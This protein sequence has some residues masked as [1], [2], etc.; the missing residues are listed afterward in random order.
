MNV[1]PHT[2]GV[3]NRLRL[4]RNACLAVAVAPLLAVG[5]DYAAVNPAATAAAPQ[6]PAPPANGEMGFVVT[7]FHPAFHNGGDKTDCPD[8][9]MGTLKDSYL[10]TLPAAR[11]T[12]LMKPENANELD[13]LWKAYGLGPNNANL[14]GNIYEF[15]DRPATPEMKGNVA[16]GLNLDGDTGDGSSTPYT[17]KHENFTSPTGERGIDYQLWRAQGCSATLRGVNSD[18][19]SDLRFGYDDNMMSGEWTQVILL[20][21][22]DSLTKDDD[23]EVIY[24]N[25][26]D[27]P[28][29][30]SNR[31]PIRNASFSVST[32]GRKVEYRNVLKGR[33]QNGV[34]ET[35]TKDIMLNG[36]G[37][38]FDLAR[39]RVRLQFQADGTVT[40]VV[41]GY[42]PILNI[43]RSARG[44]GRGSVQ[45]AG[46]D[47]AGQYVTLKKLAD[48]D[49][50]PATG[51]CRKI[52]Y[53][54]ELIG[55][56]AFVNDIAP[57]QN[58]ASK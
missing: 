26:D 30:D 57:R 17:C 41:G 35:V 24:A 20:R 12:A 7:Q 22:V 47:C 55:V 21:G 5:A 54:Y 16:W 51:Q 34:L 42:Q 11:R 49:R 14:C 38:Q 40:G 44:G 15:L 50:D 48:G 36:G 33:I 3:T 52:S 37:S 27:R 4:R 32:Q 25:T 18:G 23:V 1:E 2:S 13:R 58:V 46:I 9:M 19:K 56:P 28:I 10:R 43:L 29:A 45:V 39:G 6:L 31:Q 8:G 53:A